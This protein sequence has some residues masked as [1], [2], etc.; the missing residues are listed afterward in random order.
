MS[1]IGISPIVPKRVPCTPICDS[2][3]LA[4]FESEKKAKQR[5]KKFEFRSRKI[6][7]NKAI[8]PPK[9]SNN[10]NGFKTTLSPIE[11]VTESDLS[12][13]SSFNGPPVTPRNDLDCSMNTDMNMSGMSDMSSIDD[14]T[15]D[16]LLLSPVKTLKS[17]ELPPSS[18]NKSASVI[19]ITPLTALQHKPLRFSPPVSALKAKPAQR[20]VSGF[21]KGDVLQVTEMNV[22]DIKKKKQKKESLFYGAEKEENEENQNGSF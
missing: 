21:M 15:K 19:P 10:A 20:N 12:N 5:Q 18:R 7:Q 3:E 14:L 8:I 22:F 11:D 6:K 4:M 1:K 9:Q 2:L 17:P 13:M 16:F